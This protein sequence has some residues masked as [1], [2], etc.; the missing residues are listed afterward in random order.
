[1]NDFKSKLQQYLK[2]SSV[3]FNGEIFTDVVD[4][5]T[6]ER[7]IGELSALAPTLGVIY[8]GYN[9]G[10]ATFSTYTKTSVINLCS[11]LDNN[12]N[13]LGYDVSVVVQDPMTHV[14]YDDN[15]L[16][17]FDA[18][19]EFTDHVQ[20]YIDVALEPSIVTYNPVYV[21]NDSPT[22][23]VVIDSLLPNEDYIMTD[24]LSDGYDEPIDAVSA[25][26][27]PIVIKI[28][29]AK[30]NSEYGNYS[31]TLNTNKNILSVG[32]TYD[33]SPNDDELALDVDTINDGTFIPNFYEDFSL[34]KS[35]K[36]NDGRITPAI[37]KPKHNKVATTILESLSKEDT[38]YFD[39]ALY[40]VAKVVKVNAKGKRRI[41][42]QCQ[43][44]YK[45]DP[46][47]KTC[48]QITGSELA[49]SRISHR[50][51][52]RTK[53]SMGSGYKKRV[54]FRT[55]RAKHFRKLMGLK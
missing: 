41:K 9:E 10:I 47:R 13:I 5:S 4:D 34:V 32:V 53:K 33:Q 37:Y 6:E 50:Q 51:M 55:N 52:V 23:D 26:E 31:A 36:V 49:Q 21:G 29:S 3:E 45:Y 44:G 43:V 12:E 14:A 38:V 40:E 46:I 17:D 2:E 24:D 7:V 18:S 48:V 8:K 54:V 15:G 22:P 35:A 20:Y 30:S 16:V 19:A 25:D 42:M 11:N 28:S 27:V 1:M 39:S